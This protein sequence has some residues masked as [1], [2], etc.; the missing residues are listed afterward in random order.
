MTFRQTIKFISH[1][2]GL[3]LHLSSTVLQH[4]YNVCTCILH[5]L[6]NKS[7]PWIIPEISTH[8]Q[9]ILCWTFP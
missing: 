4:D 8:P 9:Q 2:K 5:K 3:S 7:N 1:K 6:L